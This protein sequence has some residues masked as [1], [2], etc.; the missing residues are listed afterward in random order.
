MDDRTRTGTK[1]RNLVPVQIGTKFPKNLGTDQ[2]KVKS[3]NIGPDRNITDKILKI[4][5]RT[6]IDKILKISDH[7]V[8]T[9]PG[10]RQ[11]RVQV[12]PVSLRT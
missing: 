4:L 12:G 1:L 5:D 3:E 7:A 11:I 9:G 8:H 6:R 10:S 2:N